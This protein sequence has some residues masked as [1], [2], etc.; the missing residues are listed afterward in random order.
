MPNSRQLNN[1]SPTRRGII[2]AAS[3]LPLSATVL[4]ATTFRSK[5]RGTVQSS[6]PGQVSPTYTH[7]VISKKI[8]PLGT[9]GDDPYPA[10]LI[11]GSLP[12]TTM[13]FKEGDMFR[14]LVNNKLK[15]PT[16]IHWHGLIPPSLQ[17][18]VPE[19]SQAPIEAGGS[20][21]YEFPLR[22]SGTCWY[23]SH[24]GLQE[25]QGHYGALIIE[26][27]E[28]PHPS[29]QDFVVF[30][31]D[32]LNTSPYDIIPQIR[33]GAKRP[34]L[35]PG[36]PWDESKVFTVDGT[37]WEVDVYAPGMLMN[38]QTPKEPPVFQARQGDRVRLRIINAATSTIFRVQLADHPMTV[39]AADSQPCV[40]VEIDNFIISPGERYDVLVDVKDLGAWE[41]QA[42]ALGTPQSAIGVLQTDSKQTKPSSN[43]TFGERMLSYDMLRSPFPTQLPEGPVKTFELP[44]AGDM[45]NYLW[46][47]GGEYFAEPY[48]PNPNAT[49]L[50]IQAGDQVRVIMK[51]NTSMAH[52]MHIHGHFFQVVPEGCDW[53]TPNLPVMD[54]VLVYPGETARIQFTADNPGNWL[55]HC[56]NLYHFTSGMGRVFKYQV[57]E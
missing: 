42:A 15:E 25:Q 44:L 21:Y 4:G 38:G 19:I 24:F 48:V 31:Q 51:N 37:P 52:P 46:S 26:P 2:A 8:D 14:V 7:N 23:H 36:I 18:G 5:A 3:T 50:Y 10:T 27:K 13:Y 55:F 16:T 54:T 49:P 43:T 40:P 6:T 1:T 28:E 35:P 30:L 33:K 41:L 9:A 12:G 53:D 45:K 17:D 57:S 11:N 20:M 22:Q 47:M 34:G 39:I 56:H 32:W 29:D